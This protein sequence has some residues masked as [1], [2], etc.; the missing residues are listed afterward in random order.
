MQWNVTTWGSWQMQGK[1]IYGDRPFEVLVS[2]EVD[3]LKTPGLV[4]RAPTPDAGM[5]FFCRDTFEANV[6][7]TVW[8]LEWNKD[9]KEFVCSRDSPLIDCA[10]S[11]QGGAEVGGG[12]WWTTWTATSELSKPVLALLRIPAWLQS[13]TRSLRLQQR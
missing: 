4:F 6:T 3:P 8:E 7:L 13:K 5:V 1:S 2:F 12:P 11:Q 10:T 9:T